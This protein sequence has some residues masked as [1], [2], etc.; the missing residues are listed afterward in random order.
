MIQHSV[1]LELKTLASIGGVLTVKST[2]EKR[3]KRCPKT[4]GLPGGAAASGGREEL[5]R[6]G[7][8]THSAESYAY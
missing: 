7:R 2:H 3:G 1:G 8:V 6:P 4:V 5:P